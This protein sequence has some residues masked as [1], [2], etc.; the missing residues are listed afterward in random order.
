MAPRARGG[1]ARGGERRAGVGR[2]PAPRCNY[3]DAVGSA[4]PGAPRRRAPC[5]ASAFRRLCLFLISGT[6]VEKPVSL[7][8][9]R[10]KEI[11]RGKH[12]AASLTGSECS[13]TPVSAAQGSQA[14]PGADSGAASCAEPRPQPPGSACPGDEPPPLCLPPA[15]ECPWFPCSPSAPSEQSPSGPTSTEVLKFVQDPETGSRRQP[16]GTSGHMWNPKAG[17]AG[18]GIPPD[19][20]P[21]EPGAAWGSRWRKG[22]GRGLGEP[23]WGG[24]GRRPGSNLLEGST[25]DVTRRR[26]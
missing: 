4:G 14:S 18:P 16:P 8:R 15:A 2:R 13:L 26:K 20:H 9:E 17:P 11:I 3:F 19:F 7:D 24:G 10:V 23:G 5:R 25:A 21:G 22:E 6:G 1:G 12:G